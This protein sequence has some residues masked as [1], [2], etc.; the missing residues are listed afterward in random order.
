MPNSKKSNW[1]AAK[2]LL[3]AVTKVAVSRPVIT[4]APNHSQSM[5]TLNQKDHSLSGL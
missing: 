2:S 4:I 1:L 5:R 3:S